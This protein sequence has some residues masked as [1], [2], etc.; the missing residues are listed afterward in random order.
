MNLVRTLVAAAVVAVPALSFAAQPAQQGLTR[1]QVRAELVQLQQ[2][3][4]RQS[5]D[6]NQYPVH[7]QAALARIAASQDVAS[8][9]AP[10]H[11]ANAN[12]NAVQ[13]SFGGVTSGSSAS[14]SRVKAAHAT[15]H[16]FSGAQAD[17]VG[18]EPIYAHS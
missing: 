14:G 4:Y 1:A 18:L 15:L 9:N 10:T 13:T 5:S 12:A 6:N 2:A 11:E 16:D 17:Q 8:A 3:G 7:L